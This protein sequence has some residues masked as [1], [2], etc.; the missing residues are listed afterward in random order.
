[1]ALTQIPQHPLRA[2]GPKHTHTHL[3]WSYT[4]PASVCETAGALFHNSKKSCSSL[5]E[6]IIII[7]THFDRA[8]FDV[9]R[10]M[11]ALSVFHCSWELTGNDLQTSQQLESKEHMGMNIHSINQIHFN[12]ATLCQTVWQTS[13]DMER[14]L[15][16]PSNSVCKQWKPSISERQLNEV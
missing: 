14:F 3:Q 10:S 1:M 6:K 11:R 4:L 12:H 8:V 7:I 5:K 16:N 13:A 15:E 2:P 9:L